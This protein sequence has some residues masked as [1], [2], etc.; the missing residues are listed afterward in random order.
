V[1]S[2]QVAGITGQ[3]LRMEAFQIVVAPQY[4]NMDSCLCIYQP[5]VYYR[6]H[7]Q[8]IGWQPW[9]SAGQTAG[10]TGQSLRVEAMQVRVYLL[11]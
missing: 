3:S 6:A 2:P 10:T 5:K 9:V 7:V 1:I 11:E 8:S 4:V